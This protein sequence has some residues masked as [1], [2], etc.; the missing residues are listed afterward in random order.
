MDHTVKTNRRL[1]LLGGFLVVV[2]LA[3]V[4]VLY[5]T[6]VNQYDYYLAQSVRT[7]AREETVTASRGLITDRNGKA[8][9]S[10]RSSYNLTFDSSLLKKE[11][12]E[13]AAI[14][15]LLNLCQTQNISWVDNL[16]I[17]KYAPFTYTVDQ[18]SDTQRGR[19]LTYLQGQ[20][21]VGDHLKAPD[22]TAAQLL[23]MGLTPTALLA[24][25]GAEYGL[26]AAFST[27]ESRAVL[28]VQYELALRKLDNYTAYILAEDIDATMISLLND[29]NFLG[30]K[31]TS[32]SVREYETTAAAHILGTV[33][34]IF[35][36]EKEAMTA[37][38]YKLDDLV[39]KSGVESAFEPY[40]R[41]TDGRRLVSTNSEGKVTSELYAKEPQ[42]GS[43]VELTID[44]NLQKAM[45][46]ALAETIHK[47]NAADGNTTRGAGAVVTKVGT[48]EVLA[49]ASYPTYDPAAYRRDYNALYA[50]P[51]RP[52]F[53]RATSGTYA[54]GSTFKPLTAIAAL[55]EGVITPYQTIQTR[56]HWV[57]PG[58]A[59]SYANCWIY[60]SS[61]GTHGSINITDAITVSCNYFFAEMGYRLGLDTLNKYAQAFGLGENTG[62]EIGDASGRLAENR[63][64]ENQAP[65][66]AFGQ[67]D[68]LFTPIQL[69]N[70]IATLVSGG[71]HCDAH[72]L[73]AVKSYDNAAVLA[74]GDSAPKNT[75]DISPAS[76]TAVKQGMH[77]LTTTGS[78]SS[79][80]KSCVVDAGAKTGT[81]QINKQTKNTGVLVCFAPYDKP[82]IA[83]SIV[84][85][86][87][88]S[89]AALA[90]AAVQI[91][92]AYFTTDQ[93][94]AV[95]LGE[96]QLLP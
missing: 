71:K 74:V 33:G 7:I 82:E 80:F 24:H 11:D 12:D 58:D 23:K 5:N 87:G 86:E 46:T 29:G 73:K 68:Y 21:L 14:L 83:L 78:L 38:G 13:N 67:A 75:I 41:G 79:Y 31:I 10:N 27:G 30:A 48:G 28:G 93:I 26:P 65:W 60:N 32:A 19:F 1:F 18:L 91:L 57:Y 56:G 77:N 49:L 88:G 64:G 54:P 44:L 89:G 51:A 45:E 39:G 96:N 25:M 76:L 59:N 62:I 17:S 72:L 84:I 52:L 69:S 20:K 2:L 15:R 92:N 61:R 94:G 42:P 90:S 70:Y 8:L 47:M 85:E 95:V 34:P 3:Y 55:N 35:N 66:A 16:P 36:E 53:N 50:N 6:Q 22:L 81:A 37:L 63:E 4:G 43:T 40:L 9:V